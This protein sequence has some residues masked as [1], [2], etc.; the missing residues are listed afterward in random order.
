MAFD[1][2]VSQAESGDVSSWGHTLNLKEVHFTTRE[3]LV[4]AE[5]RSGHRSRR[6]AEGEGCRCLERGVIG[7]RAL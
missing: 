6:G 1:V 7:Y 3:A 5:I 2:V 4:V